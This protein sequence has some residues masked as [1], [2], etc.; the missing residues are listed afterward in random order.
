VAAL[1]D[2]AIQ[3]RELRDA[4]RRMALDEKSRAAYLQGAEE[5]SRATLGRPLTQDELERIVARH[6]AG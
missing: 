6:R 2:L 5:H 4:E 3:F 1:T